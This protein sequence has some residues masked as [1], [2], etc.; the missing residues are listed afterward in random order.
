MSGGYF[1]RHMIAFGEIANSIER[2]IAR[3]LRPKPEKIRE[4]YWTI[5]EKDSL[6]SYHSY[7]D[8]MSFASYEDAESFL[9]LDKT[10]VKAEQKYADRRFFDDGVIFQSKKRNMSDTPDGEQIPVLYSI[11]H[12]YYDR[13]PDEADVLELSDETINAM[14]EAYRQIRIAEI[15]ATR[16]DWMMSGDDSEESFRERIKEDLAEF[17]REYASK[18]WTFLYDE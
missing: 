5:Y 11:H 14:K 6:S 15:Y 7:K 1:N 18:N 16:V 12:C 9:L 13:Y 8:Y 4:V 3:A 10:I 17:E 2:D